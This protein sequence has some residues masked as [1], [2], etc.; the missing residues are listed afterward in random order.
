MK[1]LVVI[2]MQNDFITGSLANKMADAAV[3][4][5]INYMKDFDGKI[6]FTQDTHFENYLD[7]QEGKNLPVEHCIFNTWGHRIDER[8][9]NAMDSRC[10]VIRKT[11]FG[12]KPQMWRKIFRNH[13]NPALEIEICGTLV[14]ICVIS[15]A[16]MLKALYPEAK[17]KLLTNMCGY[18]DMQDMLA[19]TII[20]KACQIEIVY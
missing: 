19:A 6:V 13:R 5:I 17:I 14:D 20:A 11:T 8:L 18:R 10:E 16:L 2:D 9:M 15:N 3:D 7:T 4:K 1:F 12:A